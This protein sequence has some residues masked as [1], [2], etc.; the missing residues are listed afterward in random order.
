MAIIRRTAESNWISKPNK[1]KILRVALIPNNPSTAG[2]NPAK[3]PGQAPPK[4]PPKIPKPVAPVWP[5]KPASLNLK[6]ERFI[7]KA[8][9]KGIKRK[10]KNKKGIINHNTKVLKTFVVS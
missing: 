2:N 1:G 8:T 7:V 4:I 10:L 6:I 3:Q 5:P 9:R